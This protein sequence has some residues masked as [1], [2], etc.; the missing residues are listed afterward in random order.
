MLKTLRPLPFLLMVM[1][2]FL[3]LLG[4][5]VWTSVSTEI[6]EPQAAQVNLMKLMQALSVLVVFV[7]PAFLFTGLFAPEGIKFLK[8]TNLPSRAFLLWGISLLLVSLP[9]IALIEELNKHLTLPASLHGLENWIRTSEAN[10]EKIENAFM[11]DNSAASLLSNVLLIGLLAALS[12]ELFFRGVLQGAIQKIGGSMHAAVWIT[13]VLF[14]AFHLQFLGFL[15]RVL[16]GAILGYCFAWSGSIWT[17][18]AMHFANNVLV[19][20]IGFLIDKGVLPASAEKMGMDSFVSATV[21]SSLS[22][23]AAGFCWFKLVRLKNRTV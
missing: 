20:L 6:V 14:S 18:V 15:P 5:S 16:L 7:L 17:T 12:E 9:F 13:A 4:L 3:M 8:I 2:Y 23:A 1:L 10:A 19:L 22:L 11:K 21:L